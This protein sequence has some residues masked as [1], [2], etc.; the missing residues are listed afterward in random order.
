MY[1]YVIRKTDR[2]VAITSQY[3]N[4]ILEIPLVMGALSQILNGGYVQE[5]VIYVRSPELVKDCAEGCHHGHLNKAHL[6]GICRT[7]L[8][9]GTMSII[10]HG[11]NHE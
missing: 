2:N 6:E 7:N 4:I 9:T 5:S 1:T 3:G 8:Q 10:F 11:M